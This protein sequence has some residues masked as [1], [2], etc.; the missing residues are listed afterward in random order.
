MD[1][2]IIA[3]ML[4]ASLFLGGIALIAFLWAI[5][6]GQFDDEEKF[7]NQAL[8]DGEDELNEAVDMEK[9][10]EALKKKKYMPE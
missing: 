3:M 10:K 5:K 4:G 8:F 1:S 7:L 9:R 2:Y 6:D